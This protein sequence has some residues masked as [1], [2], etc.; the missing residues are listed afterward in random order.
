MGRVTL[1]GFASL[2][3]AWLF[4]LLVPLVIFYFLKLKRPRLDIPSLALWR[5]VMN[6]HRV[7]SPF[8]KFKRNL[9]LLL[10]L[11]ALILV[12]L[13][14]M[15][16]FQRRSGGS[17]RRIPVL[18]DC[19][20]SMDALDKE[21]GVSR[22]AIAKKRVR[23]M[24][25]TMPEGEELC[26]V[27][28]SRTA[29]KRTG[30]TNDKRLLLEALDQIS[31]EDT[32][33]DLEDA[34]RLTQALGRS[35]AFDEVVLFSD[36]NFPVRTSFELSFK[37]N[38]QRLPQAGPNCGI[39]ACD[40]HRA[41]GGGW[42]V[43]A[44]IEASKDA[45]GGASLEILQD[46]NA[47]SSQRVNIVKG[48]GQRIVF[49]VSGERPSQLQ[50]RLKPD[51][52]DSLAS[53]NVAW[54]GLPAVRPVSVY[55]P[56][57]MVSFRHALQGLD[58]I[59]IFPD[60]EGR[61]PS[62]YDLVISD[63]REDLALAAPVSCY[64]GLIPP[65]LEKMID[66]EQKQTEVIDWR[67]DS[68]LLQ[69]V[70]L[71]DVVMMDQPKSRE[72]ITENDYAKLGYEILAHGPRGP[73]ILEKQ[74]NTGTRLFLLFHTDRSTLPYRLGFPVFVTNLVQTALKR[75]GLSE[76]A[77]SRTGVLP[78]VPAR[79]GGVCRIAGP[80]GFR[81]DGTVDEQ[82]VLSGVPAP[83]VGEY[84][85]S[86][87]GVEKGRVAASLL[88]PVETTLE[89][90]EQIQFNE[91]L[92]VSVSAAPIRNDFPFWRPLIIAV[93]CILLLEWWF[94]QKRPGGITGS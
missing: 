1:P 92:T 2:S 11:L 56:K 31:V 30:F 37:V 88:S 35:A 49:H 19:S 27:S 85:I 60:D 59:A 64:V 4:S 86:Q 55:A 45:Q 93:F 61:A 66:T 54:L 20:A 26:L 22:L 82:G 44:Q 89:S 33:G 25:E 6:D 21:G 58:A 50:I 16:P 81:T 47:I 62:T 29:R 87:N 52:P 79:A 90:A 48:N 74:E 5:Q 38:Y 42:D 43:F 51:G 83:R 73:L 34:F 41:T 17:A 28:F 75:A 18:I 63:R 46:G 84:T 39:T 78:P 23:E 67:R 9:L 32:A 7:N 94:F 24:I 69:H 36:G 80:G 13:A 70:Q 91:Q 53:D 15:Q 8:Q 3:A 40:A 57:S 77:A 71:G 76:V 68:P 12:V 65:G 72:G 14:A 10:Q